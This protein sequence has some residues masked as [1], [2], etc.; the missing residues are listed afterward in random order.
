MKR[1]VVF[2]ILFFLA[3]LVAFSQ[4]KFL[5]KTSMVQAAPGKL[6]ELIDLY[7]TRFAADSANGEPRPFWMRHAQGDKWDLLILFPVGNY[8][9]YYAAD[10]VKRRENMQHTALR[11]QIKEA[12]AWQEDIFVY[13]P[14]PEEIR[15]RFSGASFFHLEIFIALAGKAEELYKERE[16]EN[17][18][19][20]ALKRP[21]NFVFVRDQGAAWDLFTLGGYRDLKHYAESA[22]ISQA[23]QDAAAKSAGF[24]AANK[25]GPYLRTF[26][27]EHHDTLCSIVK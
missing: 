24:E 6:L 17:M 11:S 12:T 18:Y 5:W 25:I 20:K 3:P 21:E 8:S 16:M 7:K 14:A 4:P 27:R 9:E 15:K 23:D 1:K 13:G 2:S 22:D 19:G 10:R 26:I